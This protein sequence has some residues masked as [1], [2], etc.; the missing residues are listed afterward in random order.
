[1]SL[2]SFRDERRGGKWVEGAKIVLLTSIIHFENHFYLLIL[3]F[4]Y[5]TMTKA[6]FNK[7]LTPLP[8][9][10]YSVS[11]ILDAIL[12][13]DL[14]NQLTVWEEDKIPFHAVR[15]EVAIRQE[16]LLNFAWYRYWLLL[17][18]FIRTFQNE[19][20]SILILTVSLI[21]LRLWSNQSSGKFCKNL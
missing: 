20:L 17:Q 21:I 3:I 6:P 14:I 8:L 19:Q 15:A 9:A 7:S 18:L 4:I 10:S 1:M 2:R 5:A 16:C 12:W 11:G 13:T